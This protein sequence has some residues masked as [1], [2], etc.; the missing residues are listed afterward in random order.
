MKDPGMFEERY[1]V[2]AVDAQNLVVK[3]VTSGEVVTITN[4]NPAKPFSQKDYPP[5]K[6]IAISD[7]S[8]GTPS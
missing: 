1:R 4:A 6:L 8:T 3:G 2:I 5:G 7:P